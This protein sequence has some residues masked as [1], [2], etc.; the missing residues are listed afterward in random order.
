VVE[1]EAQV[2]QVTVLGRR[3][4]EKFFATGSYLGTYYSF[5]IE[6]QWRLKSVPVS[7]EDQPE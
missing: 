3:K 5:I 4:S 6:I 2:K 7:N 1:S